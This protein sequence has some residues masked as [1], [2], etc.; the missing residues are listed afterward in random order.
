[1]TT[2]ADTPD[3][4]DPDGRGGRRLRR[5]A[6]VATFLALAAA[7]LH[8]SV[9]PAI[10]L[11]LGLALALAVTTPFP[12]LT[13]RGSKII[14]QVS[15]ALLGFRMELGDMAREAVTGMLFAVATIGGT[16]ALGW[17]LARPLRIAGDTA[18]LVSGGTAICGGSAIA[19]IAPAIGARSASVAVAMAIVFVLNGLA[20]FLF[21]PIGRLLELS[22]EQFGT[23]A[24]VA[25]HD[26]SSVVGAA[27]VYDEA[28]LDTATTVKLARALWIVPV[29]L[30]AG[31]LFR[32]AADRR[33]AAAGGPG[34]AA[35]AGTRP[36]LIPW[37]IAAFVLASVARS[38]VPGVAD[39]APVLGDVA[40]AGL[41]LTL[42]LIG[43]G[44]S[45]ATLREVGPRALVLGVSLWL[46][47]SGASLGV[48]LSMPS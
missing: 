22:P 26:V 42:F 15:V 21:P 39:V 2:P 23:W 11:A 8:P 47:I 14:L 25:I 41:S 34:E 37:F 31:W 6:V 46:A 32:R 13:K 36:P 35:A 16:L 29:A 12:W 9:S 48:V 43:T 33:A 19:A 44:L 30:G 20:L 1:M 5:G 17:L 10:A 38:F 27:A 24:G 40:T 28:A 4:S 45:L 7:S 3:P 18:T